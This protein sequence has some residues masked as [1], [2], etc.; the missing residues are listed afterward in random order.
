MVAVTSIPVGIVLLQVRCVQWVA[1]HNNNVSLTQYHVFI[2]VAFVWDRSLAKYIPVD[3][4][5]MYAIV[6]NCYIMAIVGRVSS[7]VMVVRVNLQ[8]RHD[9]QEHLFGL[10]LHLYLDYLEGRRRC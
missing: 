4:P 6:F 9:G 10:G 7:C 1:R 2:H 5:P 8:R 3:F